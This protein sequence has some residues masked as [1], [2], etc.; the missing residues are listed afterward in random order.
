MKTQAE[1]INKAQELLEHNPEALEFICIHNEFAHAADDIVDKEDL[2]AENKATKLLTFLNYYRHPYYVKHANNGLEMLSLINHIM[3]EI[4]VKWEKSDDPAKINAASIL[5]HNSIGMLFAV[6]AIECG[7]NTAN[8]WASEFMEHTL[9]A[10]LQD[11][12]FKIVNP[13]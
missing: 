6:I 12:E 10:H 7:S 9:Y 11:E 13:A 1:F 4:S 2:S 5:R 8:K 3:Y